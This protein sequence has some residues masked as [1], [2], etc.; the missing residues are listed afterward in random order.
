[1]LHCKS[2]KTLR[3]RKSRPRPNRDL[4]RHQNL[5]TCFYYHH[6]PLNKISSESIYNFLSNVATKQTD[7]CL[8]KHSDCSLLPQMK[9]KYKQEVRIIYVVNLWSKMITLYYYNKCE[10]QKNNQS[11]QAIFAALES[12]VITAYILFIYDF[13]Q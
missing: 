13:L 8:Q 2:D 6:E 9:V 7:K 11:N 10:R 4:R 1:M 3:E 5:I 12:A